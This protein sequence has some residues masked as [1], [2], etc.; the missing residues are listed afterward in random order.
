MKLAK[1]HLI[2]IILTLSIILL[3]V[4]L[5]RDTGYS[6]E[7]IRNILLIS[8]DT[9]RADYL[10]CY[11]Y[12]HKT[13]P[14]ID[15]LADQAILFENVVSPVPMT[16]PAHAS[17]FTGTI[18]PYHGIH[19]NLSYRLDQSN[20]TLAQILKENGFTT[21]AIVSAFVMD[22]RFGLDKGFDSYNDKFEEQHTVLAGFNERKGDET[23]RIALNWL[24]QH[25]DEKF[26]LLLHYYDPHDEYEP[27]EPFASKFSDNL[28]AGEIAFT[29]HCIGQVLEKIKQLQLDDT[30]LIIITADHGEMLGEHGE[31]SHAYFI[32]Q[33]VVK[34]PLIFKLPR[35]HKAEIFRETVGLVDIVPTICGLLDIEIPKDIHGVD[36]SNCLTKNKPPKQNRHLYC[37]SLTPTKYNANSLLSVVTNRFKYIQTTVP[38]LYDLEKDLKENNNLAKAQPQRARILK[39]KLAQILEQ[40]VRE[41]T[42]S[43]MH[44]D[45]ETRKRLESLGYV[46]GSIDESFEFDQTKDNPKNSLDFHNLYLELVARIGQ[47]RFTEAKNLAQK[48]IRQKPDCYIG[49]AQMVKVAMHQKSYP[50]VI[51]HAKKALELKPDDAEMYNDL[52]MALQYQNSLVEAAD[53][54]RSALKIN[55]DL[56]EASYNLGTVLTKQGKLDQ[57]VACYRQA[58]KLNPDFADAYNNLAGVLKEQNKLDQAITN[59]R[60]ALRINPELVEAHCSLALILNQQGDIEGTISH[61]QKALKLKPDLP[62]AHYNLANL[63]QSKNNVEKAIE[64]YREALQYKDDF[65]EAH[66]NLGNML[67]QQGN[68]D[69]AID[70]YRQVLQINPDFVAAYYNMADALKLQNKLDQAVK[71]YQK[72]LSLAPENT[73]I[74]FNISLLLVRQE[75]YEQAINQFVEILR[76]KPD[77]PEAHYRLA[78][79]YYRQ[80][81]LDLALVHWKKSI[82]LKPDFVSALNSLAWLLATSKDTGIQSPSEA[83]K[84]AQKAC[85]LTAYSQPIFLDT[86]AAAY[87]AENDF[88]KA[89]ESA[90]K[91]ISLALDADNAKLAEQIQNRLE[92][93]RQNLP[94][95]E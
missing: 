50:Q 79:L 20:I 13:T 45:T 33:P 85:Q 27:P 73:A 16:L 59:Y 60:N 8:I 49:Y 30:T 35:Q 23:T 53:S 38:E 95:T 90:Q 48:M 46:A 69:Q 82:E 77:W 91:A 72:A 12:K 61:Y 64:H 6:P 63:F 10:G 36:L 39:D 55:P 92:L 56:V 28:Y 41:S 88:A 47:K 11:G 25:K 31:F 44:S 34:V 94:Y 14:N 29:D 70:H 3:A 75:K 7:N 22:S 78:G 9:C 58:L 17:M 71:N 87:A 54:Y 1:K 5:S 40:S 65:L 81:N 84:L 93:Y 52:G 80:K 66:N 62:Q 43:K 4:W 26:F 15:T 57:A 74:M 24:D 86:L 89:I 32:Y 42:L 18:P 19:D 83:V 37:E 21:A 67:K 68:L 76:L 51:M 2:L